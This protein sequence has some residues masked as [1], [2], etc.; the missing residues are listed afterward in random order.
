MTL[1]VL[2]VERRADTVR[3]EHLSRRVRLAL[4]TSG[5]LRPRLV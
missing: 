5:A 1:L 3:V 4:Y 2:R